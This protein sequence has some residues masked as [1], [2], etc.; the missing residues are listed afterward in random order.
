MIIGDCPVMQQ[1]IREQADA[2]DS[3]E[4]GGIPTPTGVGG[5]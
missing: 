3:E 4:V 5:I 1:Y 2:L